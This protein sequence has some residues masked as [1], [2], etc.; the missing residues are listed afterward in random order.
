MSMY[1]IFAFAFLWIAHNESNAAPAF[2]CHNHR[3]S[4]T[5]EKIVATKW[6][7]SL[8]PSHTYTTRAKKICIASSMGAEEAFDFCVSIGKG[9][10]LETK[11]LTFPWTL[12]VEGSL[13]GSIQCSKQGQEKTTTRVR[14]SE[15]GELSADVT[16]VHS[17]EVHGRIIGNI[18]C[19]H[20]TVGRS[21]EVIGDVHVSSM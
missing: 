3:L 14:V 10:S 18:E 21:G 7:Q 2:A 13:K 6:G 17:V 15:G 1:V 19:Q 8:I 20:L 5:R 9:S 11:C 16:C 12:L 4:Q